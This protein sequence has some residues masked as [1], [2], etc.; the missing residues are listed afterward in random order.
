MA[1]IERDD[2]RYIANSNTLERC[3]EMERNWLIAIR[4]E[5]KL[6]QKYVSGQIGVTQP[7]YS[8]IE[9]GKKNPSVSTAKA[10]A[11]VLGFD[12]TRFYDEP[13]GQPGQSNA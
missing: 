1:Y 3:D 4:E 13:D 8:N 7:S 2:S 5:K 11:A 10:I 9:N 12:W 6:S